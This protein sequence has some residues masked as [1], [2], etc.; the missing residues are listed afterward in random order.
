M[1]WRGKIGLGALGGLLVYI[2]DL[3]NVG[4]ARIMI[5]LPGFEFLPYAAAAVAAV[6]FLVVG[7]LWALAHRGE[8]SRLR[9][10]E[11]GLLVPALFLTWTNGA[12]LGVARNELYQV[13]DP[14]AATTTLTSP[15]AQPAWQG[16][17][18]TFP[19]P[20]PESAEIKFLRAITGIERKRT[21]Y[22][23]AAG[24]RRVEP[25]LKLAETMNREFKEFKAVVYHPYGENP[26]YKVVIGEDMTF[27][28]AIRLRDKAIAAGIRTE[29]SVIQHRK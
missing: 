17:V 13:S 15:Y 6:P 19:V 7:A 23:V 2:A 9:V 10:F 1:T 27:D 22:V 5:N 8:T 4:F 26:F 16:A 29:P 3:Y 24:Y 28:R 20:D 25:A 11:Y 21:W 14:R 12:D 18:K